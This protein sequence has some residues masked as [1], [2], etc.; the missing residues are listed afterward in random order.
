M[1]ISY[2]HLTKWWTKDKVYCLSS[3]IQRAV[4]KKLQPLLKHDTIKQMMYVLS[5]NNNNDQEMN[6]LYIIS[7]FKISKYVTWT[8]L[9]LKM[10]SLDVNNEWFN[11]DALSLCG[12]R[13]YINK[14]YFHVYCV[15]VLFFFRHFTSM[16]LGL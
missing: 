10:T 8:Q 1:I 15:Q 14:K 6:T 13:T 4:K 16:S 5:I 7:H 3:Q 2:E 12:I 11:L 9:P